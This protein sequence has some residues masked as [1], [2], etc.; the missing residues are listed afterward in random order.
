LGKTLPGQSFDER[1]WWANLGRAQFLAAG[2]DSS[3]DGCQIHVGAEL[4]HEPL[5]GIS[6]AG[7]VRWDSGYRS[8]W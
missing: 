7:R 4:E 1:R 6:Q 3:A 2:E 5:G 8:A